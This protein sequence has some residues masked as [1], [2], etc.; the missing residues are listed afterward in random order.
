MLNANTILMLRKKLLTIGFGQTQ[1]Q[2]IIAGQKANH[3]AVDGAI[4]TF[5]PLDFE[6]F[7][8]SD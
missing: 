4:R 6:V 7:D 5:R 3:V 8:R 2:L 1:S